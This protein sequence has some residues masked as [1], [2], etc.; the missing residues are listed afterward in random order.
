MPYAVTMASSIQEAKRILLTEAFDV[1]VTDFH[2]GDGT[3]FDVLEMK[4]EAKVI[5]ATGAGSEEIAVKAM[6]AG[7]SDYLIKDLDGSYLKLLPV[8]VDRASEP[9]LR[10]ATIDYV[11]V[12]TGAGFT[13][14]NPSLGGSCAC[15][16]R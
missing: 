9:Y 14:R 16:Q 1:V 6:K 3:A 11:D 15:G 13:V 4:L 7:A 12:P 5:V 2:L 8:A 10:G